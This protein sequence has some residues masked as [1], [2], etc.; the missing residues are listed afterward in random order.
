MLIL[1]SDRFCLV[2][3]VEGEFE[4]VFKFGRRVLLLI[5]DICRDYSMERW[6][7][8]VFIVFGGE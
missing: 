6:Y 7:F 5:S 3:S 4:I 1:I 2:C 8:Y